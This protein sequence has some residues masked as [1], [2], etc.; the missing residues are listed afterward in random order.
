VHVDS[1]KPTL[2]ARGNQRLKLKSDEPLSNLAFK[3]NLRR[4]SKGSVF[5]KLGFVEAGH[6]LFA[7]DLR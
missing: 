1:I 7:K 5:A 3:I 4:Y 2:K 6:Y